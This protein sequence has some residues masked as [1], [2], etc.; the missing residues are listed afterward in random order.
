MIYDTFMFAGELDMLEC[1]LYEWRD[2]PDAV[3][4]IAEAPETFTGRPKG[5]VF[6]RHEKRFARWAH[7][8]R[9]IA[10]EVTGDPM[11]RQHA[12]RELLWE[13]LHDASDDDTVVHGDVDEIVL[14]AGIPALRRITGPVKFSARC[15]VFAV[16]WEYP[17]RW[18]GGPVV[19][20]AGK[21]R[22]LAREW[23]SLSFATLRDNHV[24]IGGPPWEASLQEAWHLTWVGGLKA[25]QQKAVSFAHADNAPW[26]LP[27]L[28]DGYRHGVFWG[29]PD[30][31]FSQTPLQ[32]HARD[33]D[34]S[35]PRWVHERRCPPD[36]F[37]P[38]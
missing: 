26:I 38:R 37:R 10:G 33:V 4:V 1:H 20:R 9:Y 13:G 22:C 16:D 28:E 15:A 7:R 5:L 36:W 18:T 24:L 31:W 17:W 32:L 2:I 30:S 35:W 34:D 3:H 14:A 12:S 29:T 25:A 23:G 11:A 8:I 6:P 21:F 27:R 19:I